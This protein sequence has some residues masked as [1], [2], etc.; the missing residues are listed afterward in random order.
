[1][2][3]NEDTRVDRVPMYKVISQ[4]I[5]VEISMK[6]DN[7]KKIQIKILNVQYP[8]VND[9]F[10]LCNINSSFRAFFKSLSEFTIFPSFLSRIRFTENIIHP[11]NPIRIIN[12]SIKLLLIKSFNINPPNQIVQPIVNHF[13]KLYLDLFNFSINEVSII[14]NF[15][16]T[17]S[18]LYVTYRLQT[19][20]F[21][22]IYPNIAQNFVRRFLILANRVAYAP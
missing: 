10:R 8:T 16:V 14:L 2:N 22:I 3:I 18:Y 11:N 1:M 7:A 17:Q 5:K 12:P 4:T 20:G 21:K 9:L 13:I 6:I 15:Y 19:Y